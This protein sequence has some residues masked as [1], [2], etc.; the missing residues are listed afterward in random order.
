MVLTTTR[1]VI[2]NRATRKY[3]VTCPGNG[4][5]EAEFKYA[6]KVGDTLEE[7][8]KTLDFYNRSLLSSLASYDFLYEEAEMNESER[9]AVKAMR[10]ADL[11]LIEVWERSEIVLT[12]VEEE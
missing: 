8:K 3:L 7:A 2:Y 1:F 12:A 4:V 5:R 9:K 10:E 6:V 11:I